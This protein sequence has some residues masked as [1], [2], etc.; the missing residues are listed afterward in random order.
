MQI[1]YQEKIVMDSQIEG[2]RQTL[3]IGIVAMNTYYYLCW[4]HKVPT[5]DSE[6]NN[7]NLP[8]LFIGKQQSWR[9][10]SS[11]EVKKTENNMQSEK[12]PL[13]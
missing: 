4:S 6:G 5:L 8:S 9:D 2:W 11:F 10:L 12:N 3:Y 1:Q 7:E 13:C